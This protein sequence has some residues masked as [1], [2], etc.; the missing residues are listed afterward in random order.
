MMD[1]RGKAEQA[2]RQYIKQLYQTS[3]ESSIACV[4]NVI[5]MSNGAVGGAIVGAA[6]RQVLSAM[7]DR[8]RALLDPRSAET[9][10]PT[11]N[12]TMGTL[13]SPDTRG[14]G[15]ERL[16]ATASIADD[17]GTGTD[18]PDYIEPFW[19]HMKECVSREKWDELK[20]EM[21]SWLYNILPFCEL[22]EE[23]A[24][25]LE[26]VLCKYLRVVLVGEGDDP[27][28]DPE[29]RIWRRVQPIL[30]RMENDPQGTE[31]VQTR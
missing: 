30:D 18:M 4:A 13:T 12:P 3:E 10:P 24:F 25:C 15:E 7:L 22:R 1:D 8:F 31:P 5:V 27:S 19:R 17:G 16:V 28:E 29:K 20:P 21:N 9:Q 6:P 11:S 2:V 26:A 14:G 23:G